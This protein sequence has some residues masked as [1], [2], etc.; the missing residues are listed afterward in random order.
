MSLD[1]TGAHIGVS[2]CQAC[3][4]SAVNLSHLR[5]RAGKG[6]AGQSQPKLVSPFG[7]DY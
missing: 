3:L 2:R 5:G 1:M 7:S 6:R 4:V